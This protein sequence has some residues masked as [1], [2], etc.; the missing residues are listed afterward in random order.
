MERG[1]AYRVLVGKWE[2]KRPFARPRCRWKDN[3][4]PD[5]EEIGREVY[6]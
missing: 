4:K 5:P 1:G 2:G 6:N 3:I